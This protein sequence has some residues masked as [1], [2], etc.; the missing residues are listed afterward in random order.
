M[1]PFL[2]LLCVLL[3]CSG[4]GLIEAPG[5]KG[6]P[7]QDGAPGEKGEQGPPGPPGED[8]P[9]VYAAA[10]LVP[11]AAADATGSIVPM[12]EVWDSERGELC[13]PARHEGVLYCLPPELPAT[14]FA[15]YVHA[16]CSATD[17]RVSE[18]S[19]APASYPDGTSRVLFM[20]TDPA[21]N[22]RHM[23]R[24]ETVTDYYYQG[25][26]MPCQP[27][28]PGLFASPCRWHLPDMSAFAALEHVE[29]L[30]TP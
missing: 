20:S 5:E 16:G 17:E 15:G 8:A 13:V 9:V 26:G 12:A 6:D 22:Q 1:K 3:G 7:G 27:A 18:C 11:L 24:F 21:E 14:P 29:L 30:P 19:F 10:R 28:P 4:G 2:L 23:Q 25:S